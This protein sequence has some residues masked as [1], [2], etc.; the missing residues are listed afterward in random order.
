MATQ[1]REEPATEGDTKTHKPARS[2][3]LLAN[4][5]HGANFTPGCCV[6]GDPDKLQPVPP[7]VDPPAIR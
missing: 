3:G 2:K 6:N 5:A 1:D 7:P 4:T